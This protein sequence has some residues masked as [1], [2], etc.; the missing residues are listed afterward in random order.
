MVFFG[1]FCMSI[2][3]GVLFN[4]PVVNIALSVVICFMIS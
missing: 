2:T 4:T 3:M 1:N